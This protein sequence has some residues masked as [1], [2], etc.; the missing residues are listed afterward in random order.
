MWPHFPRWKTSSFAFY[1]E[2]SRIS[3]SSY[4]PLN[5]SIKTLYNRFEEKMKRKKGKNIKITAF[6]K[7]IQPL[8]LSQKHFFIYKKTYKLLLVV[9]NLSKWSEQVDWRAAVSLNGR[10]R[11][12]K[13]DQRWIGPR[14]LRNNQLFPLLFCF[15][16]AR[17]LALAL[18]LVLSTSLL[19]VCLSVRLSATV[20][21]SHTLFKKWRKKINHKKYET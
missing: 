20:L 18:V 15:P 16:P 6:K 17:S 13:I 1:N 4:F 10:H 11:S 8:P 19:S 7:H 21:N 2:V 5:T 14:R 12:L 9:L 3:S